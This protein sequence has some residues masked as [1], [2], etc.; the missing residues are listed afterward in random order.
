MKNS[1]P[2]QL[3]LGE[4]LEDFPSIPNSSWVV[5]YPKYTLH[6]SLIVQIP[7]KNS[8]SPTLQLLPYAIASLQLQRN[9]NSLPEP[10]VHPSHFPLSPHWHCSLPRTTY[11]HV[12]YVLCPRTATTSYNTGRVVHSKA[13]GAPGLQDTPTILRIYCCS[14]LYLFPFHIS[15][16]SS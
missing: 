15:I 12:H 16:D 8:F 14:L 6:S 5:T 11:S 9:K 3:L 1:N 10:R 13:S 2:L 7:T 4:L